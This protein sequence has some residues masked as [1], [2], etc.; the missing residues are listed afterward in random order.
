MVAKEIS[1]VICK[2]FFVLFRMCS[3]C[4]D[5]PSQFIYIMTRGTREFL[6]PEDFI[7]LVQDVVDTHPGLTFLKEATEFHSRYVH[8]VNNIM[9]CFDFKGCCSLCNS[10][11][12]YTQ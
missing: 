10:S 7:P 2:T 6:I 8:T 11:Q 1:L 4:H 9:Y 5:K 3:S 12:V